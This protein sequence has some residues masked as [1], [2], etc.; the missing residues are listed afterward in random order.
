MGVIVET[1]WLRL[2]GHKAI[3]TGMPD[4]V[5][6][7][8]AVSGRVFE[9]WLH[10]G[11]PYSSSPGLVRFSLSS[12]LHLTFGLFVSNISQQHAET[13][14][15]HKNQAASPQPVFSIELKC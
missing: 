12:V 10:L 8:D 9:V 11:P 1:A 14:T 13:S 6:V 3:Q 7:Y 15:K 2:D 4:S 5:E